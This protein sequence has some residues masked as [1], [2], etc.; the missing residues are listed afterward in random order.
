M[1]TITWKLLLKSDSNTVYNLLSTSEGRRKFWSED[2][3]E[4][5]N[6]IH[7]LFPNGQTCN[8][9]ITKKIPNKEFH[10]DYFNSLVKFKLKSTK[11][12]GTD[13][14]LINEN[15]VESDFCEV[16][17]GWISVLMNLKAVADFQCDLRNHDPKKTWDQDYADN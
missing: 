12:G 15:I 16:K 11:K 7:F 6:I 10:L 9:R 1:K 5:G 8:S 3:T 13:L 2:E 4:E 14:T 17:S